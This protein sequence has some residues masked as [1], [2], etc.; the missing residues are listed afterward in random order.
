[1]NVYSKVGTSKLIKN[2]EKMINTIEK[3]GKGLILASLAGLFIVLAF[4]IEPVEGV[5][6]I[7]ASVS[8]SMYSCAT[9]LEDAAITNSFG[10]ISND[11]VYSATTST[12]TITSSGTI[13]VKVI[14][15]EHGDPL[16]PGLYSTNQSHL[17]ESPNAAFDASAT[18][19]ANTEGYGITASTT[20]T[21]GID[22]RY[23]WATGTASYVVGG[24]PTTTAATV[25]SSGASAVSGEIIS[26][27]YLINL[28]LDR[29]LRKSIQ[30]RHNGRVAWWLIP[31]NH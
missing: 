27:D 9:A 8:T 28:S 17:I 11:A 7:S 25:A 18:L 16:S 3:I 26:I 14:G 19:A 1:M 22:V 30:A 15:A 21:M 2:K 12:T 24:L 13:Y 31:Q 6:N 5:L 29:T 10:T 20:G 23:N 4:P